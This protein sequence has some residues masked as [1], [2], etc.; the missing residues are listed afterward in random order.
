MTATAKIGRSA[1]TGVCFGRR[2]TRRVLLREHASKDKRLGALS[3]RQLLSAMFH[4]PISHGSLSYLGASRHFSGNVSVR[5]T[6]IPIL[7]V[8]CGFYISISVVATILYRHIFSFVH[9]EYLHFSASR[10]LGG[11]PGWNQYAGPAG[12][13]L[14]RFTCVLSWGGFSFLPAGLVFWVVEQRWEAFWKAGWWLD[15]IGLGWIR[16]NWISACI[17]PGIL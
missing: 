9:L 15:W 4:T 7:Y 16:F 10:R 1:R 5:S 6:T 11:H 8:L 17:V 13:W 3:I 14:G 2:S 12:R